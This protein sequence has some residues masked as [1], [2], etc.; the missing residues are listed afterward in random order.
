VAHAIVVILQEVW[1]FEFSG[2]VAV[3]RS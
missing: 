3:P 2:A 1:R